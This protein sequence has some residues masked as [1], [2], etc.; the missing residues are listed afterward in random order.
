MVADFVA[1]RVVAV[2]WAAGAGG[3]VDPAA[4]GADRGTEDLEPWPRRTP[5]AHA[6]PAQWQ[7]L[8]D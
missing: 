4:E 5:V 1:V 7:A 6:G 3:L 8:A 2:R